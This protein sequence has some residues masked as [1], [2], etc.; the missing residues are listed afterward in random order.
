MLPFFSNTK[1][2]I[3]DQLCPN[4]WREFLGNC[5]KLY[6]NSI[7]MEREEASKTCFEANSKLS[8]ILS[9]DE[10]L[11]I[12]NYARAQNPNKKVWVGG[13][14][15]SMNIWKWNEN[16]QTEFNYTKWHQLEPDSGMNCMYLNHLTNY[17][18]HDASCGT[19]G[20]RWGILLLLCKK[21]FQ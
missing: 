3:A 8:S 20:K 10:Q 7:Y 16:D 19:E 1:K 5:Y 13:K 21:S 2:S 15:N 6:E 4:E 11:F 9:S 17:S 18:W 14:R 12:S